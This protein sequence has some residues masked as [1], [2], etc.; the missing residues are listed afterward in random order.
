MSQIALITG[1]S[2]GI[3]AAIALQLAEDG[4]DIWLNYRSDDAGAEKT[5]AAIREM[6]RECTLLKFD[7]TDEEEVENALSPLLQAEVPYIVVNN[8]GFAR[9]SIMMMM[10]SDDWNK[11]LQVHLSGFF[12]VTKPVV[13]RMLRKRTGRIIN[14]ASTSGETGVAGQTNYSA[15]KAGLIGATRSLAVEVAKRN[16][17]VNAVTPGFIETDMVAELPVDQIKQQIPL[18]RL[19][20]PE[21]VAGVVSFLCS[22]KAG[23]ITGQTIAVNGGIHT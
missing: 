4:Y 2:K 5:A 19:G 21:E 23:Y 11:V 1:A 14:I 17:L 18:K 16:I 13:S 20:T 7:V 22:D 12:N 3:G 10:S 8:A 6:D 9:D 15:A